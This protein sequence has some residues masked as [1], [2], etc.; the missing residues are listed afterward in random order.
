MNEK[1]PW[2]IVLL[3]GGGFALAKGSEV[4]KPRPLPSPLEGDPVAGKEGPCFHPTLRSPLVGGALAAAG[5]TRLRSVQGRG[6]KHS[7]KDLCLLGFLKPK[8]R[9]AHLVGRDYL[10]SVPTPPHPTPPAS[11]S[12]RRRMPQL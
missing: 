6:R 11:P 2:N 4:R 12:A 1:M 9:Q 5:E 3:L 8:G 10:F 7:H